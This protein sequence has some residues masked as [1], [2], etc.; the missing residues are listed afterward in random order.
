MIPLKNIISKSLVGIVDTIN[1][2][3]S[4][5]RGLEFAKYNSAW[6]EEFDTI[7]YSVNGDLDYIKNYEEQVNTVLRKPSIEILYSDNL[8]EAFG[9]MDNDRKIFDYSKGKDYDY[10][11]KFSNDIIAQPTIFDVEIDDSKDFFYINNIG[12]AAFIN[13]TKQQ[14]LANIKDY[15]Y[16]Y[17]QT[18]YYIIINKINKWYPS[19]E[20]TI[21]LKQQHLDAAKENPG[22]RPWEAVQGC[23]CEHMLSKTI[24]ENNLQPSH[25]LSDIETQNI[26]DFVHTY[27]V[28]DGSHKNIMYDRIGQLCHYH[29]LNHPVANITNTPQTV[30]TEKEYIDQKNNRVET[31]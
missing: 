23:D 6:L 18:N 30:I 28:G 12:Y 13:T 8:G 27:K 19:Y 9:A 22:I 24:R 25:L 16:F 31:L 3:R 15:S 29:I 2:T 20:E 11:W 7:L 21:D 1:D 10:V 26:I 4:Y 17:P 5:Q 14:L